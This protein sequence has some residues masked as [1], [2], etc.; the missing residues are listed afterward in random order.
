VRDPVSRPHTTPHSDKGM[1]SSAPLPTR[2]FVFID[3]RSHTEHILPREHLLNFA[4]A[5][6]EWGEEST[7]LFADLTL[8][9]PLL[10]SVSGSARDSLAAL[11]ARRPELPP[12]PRYEGPRKDA[13][14]WKSI[15]SWL[16]DS[17]L[18]LDAV[19]P[20]LLSVGASSRCSGAYINSKQEFFQA[21]RDFIG[22][23]ATSV[24]PSCDL[25]VIW[26]SH[27]N[28][29]SI[30]GTTLSAIRGGGEYHAHVGVRSPD[31]E[32]NSVSRH[33][34][35]E[36]HA[37]LILSLVSASRSSR[38]VWAV[39][40]CY[41]ANIV[42][43][44]GRSIAAKLASGSAAIEKTKI[45]K[46]AVVAD[47]PVIGSRSPV[48]ALSKAIY[49]F[50]RPFS[51]PFSSPSAAS[52]LVVERTLSALVDNLIGAERFMTTSSTAL[53][54]ERDLRSRM[55]EEWVIPVG[56][57]GDQVEKLQ[58]GLE[59]F[60]A[61]WPLNRANLTGTFRK[62]LD[63][64]TFETGVRYGVRGDSRF[65]PAYRAAETAALERWGSFHVSDDN[66]NEIFADALRAAASAFESAATTGLLPEVQA[67]FDSAKT[68]N[69]L[70]QT[71]DH[72]DRVFEEY[73]FSA[74]ANDA[75]EINIDELVGGRE[76]WAQL[77][78]LVDAA[79]R[80]R[81]F[82]RLC[83][84]AASWAEICA[85]SVPLRLRGLADIVG[86]F[87]NPIDSTRL[88]IA[89]QMVINESGAM[90]GDSA[91]GGM[92][93]PRCI[94]SW[95]KA[96]ATPRLGDLVCEIHSEYARWVLGLD[97]LCSDGISRVWKEDVARKL[98]TCTDRDCGIVAS[99]GDWE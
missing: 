74:G 8:L 21:L 54:I 26:A 53:Q 62:R 98:A 83:R 49:A 56:E 11:V 57:V 69:S 84:E 97:K 92:S 64:W 65:D 45:P 6:R 60:R 85:A 1:S 71:V 94:F 61:L 28:Y 13:D 77:A 55:L 87:E 16:A 72:P 17:S 18:D 99:F 50:D 88:V 19:L 44:I 5:A 42:A 90:I 91:G 58:G 41:S 80:P 32:Q 29:I 12:R 66:A 25:T 10:G 82:A 67:R 51:V 33:F 63:N 38:C 75:V 4:L 35:N 73:S 40:C 81:F 36:D 9:A 79:G 23:V 78:D 27:G 39:H 15:E 20:P 43:C 48:R 37:S 30:P 14:A 24:S 89:L 3:L 31:E 95:A 52:S 2:A 76:A 34:E 46:I 7:F 22:M 59:D 86:S 70:A 47:R 93:L 96:T 68:V